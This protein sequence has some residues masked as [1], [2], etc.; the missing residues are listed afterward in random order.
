MFIFLKDAEG[1]RTGGR[2]RKGKKKKKGKVQKSGFGTE[3]GKAS[4]P[5]AKVYL[6]PVLET[7]YPD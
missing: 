6:N 7:C 3:H 5:S 4:S 1:C 2:K